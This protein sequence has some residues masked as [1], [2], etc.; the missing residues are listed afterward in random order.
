MD[1]LAIY[2][3]DKET[4]FVLINEAEAFNKLEEIKHLVTINYSPTQTL[5]TKFQKLL[6]KLRKQNKSW[7]TR[8][9][10]N[11]TLLTAPLHIYME[12]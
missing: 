12:S 2:P 1:G 4:G 10:F 7:I 6:C 11:Y 8:H 3:I 9:I 5:M